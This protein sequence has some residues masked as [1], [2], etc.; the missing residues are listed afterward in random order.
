MILVHQEC[1]FIFRN[2]NLDSVHVYFQD[3]LYEN[4]IQT[5]IQQTLFPPILQVPPVNSRSACTLAHAHQCL[6][7]TLKNTRDHWLT[8]EYPTKSLNRLCGC[9]G[10]SVFAERTCSLVGND[11]PRLS[12]YYFILS[13]SLLPLFESQHGKY[14]L[15]HVY[16]GKT[17][18]SLHIPSSLFRTVSIQYFL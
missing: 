18:I 17:Q 16:P 8:T 3:D 11:V 15:W 7:Y 5:L 2:T 14:T 12:F 6:F 9:A 4:A 1:S 10:R 13:Q